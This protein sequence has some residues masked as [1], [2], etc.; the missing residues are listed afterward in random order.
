M[1]ELAPALRSFAHQLAVF[2]DVVPDG[3]GPWLLPLQR[4]I[5]PMRIPQTASLGDPDGVAGLSRRGPYERLLASEWLFALEE[6]D[7][8]IRRAVM[9][10]HMFL[11]PQYREPSGST[12]SVVLFDTGPLALGAPRLAQLALLIVL[13]RRA[14]TA[15]AV[16]RLGV[17]Q[18]PTAELFD[19]DVPA[20][21]RWLRARSWNAAEHHQAAWCDRLASQ[22]VQDRWVIGAEGTR[23][24]ADRVGAHAVTIEEL[25][26]P[27]GPA[28]QVRTYP[29]DAV[30]DAALLS[31][32][33]IDLALRLLRNPSRGK[34]CGR[35]RARDRRYARRWGD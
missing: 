7:E 24:T 23:A 35:R 25:E 16:F 20:I 32:P 17:L 8:F 22:Q 1:V 21:G 26:L 5:G 4:V 29:R 28:L 15:G 33:P 3:L 34:R 27:T 6:P 11:A 18:D 10:E 19:F 30:G 13:A 12:T 9:H 14:A 31:L 2:A